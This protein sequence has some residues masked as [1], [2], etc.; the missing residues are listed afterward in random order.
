MN[1]LKTAVRPPQNADQL[2]TPVA[3]GT[4]VINIQTQ[5]NLS[6]SESACMLLVRDG[7]GNLVGAANIGMLPNADQL[8][9]SG[10]GQSG[11]DSPFPN[12]GG[13]APTVQEIELNM[14]GANLYVVQCKQQLGAQ[15]LVMANQSQQVLQSLFRAPAFDIQGPLYSL[16]APDH[17]QTPLRQNST[18][19]QLAIATNLLQQ[20]INNSTGVFAFAQAAYVADPIFVINNFSVSGNSRIINN[21]NAETVVRKV[22]G[23]GGTLT[24]SG[25]G[26]TS[27]ES[28]NGT[29]TVSNTGTGK[30]AVAGETVN[31]DQSVT[32]GNDNSSQTI[33][34][35]GLTINST[36]TAQALMSLDNGIGSQVN[37]FNTSLV[38]DN[39]NSSTNP[40]L[41]VPANSNLCNVQAIS[42]A[43]TNTANPQHI[44]AISTMVENVTRSLL[45]ENVS[46]ETKNQIAG[47]QTPPSATSQNAVQNLINSYVTCISTTEVT[48]NVSNLQRSVNFGGTLI[49]SRTSPK[50][51]QDLMT[52]LDTIM[53]TQMPQMTAVSVSP[54]SAYIG[55]TITLTFTSN[56]SL[57][58][59]PNVTILGRQ[60]SVTNTSDMNYTATT[61]VTASDTFFN[62]SIDNIIG[63]NG[64]I[65]NSVSATTNGSNVTI[66]KSAQAV[67]A[68]TTLTPPGNYDTAL[69]VQLKTSTDNA[70]IKYTTDGSQPSDASGNIYTAPISVTASMTIKAVA[71]LN[72]ATSSIMTAEYTIIP[73]KGTV[74][75][76]IFSVPGGSYTG[77]FDLSITCATPGAKIKYAFF[78]ESPRGDY[79]FKNYSGPINLAA[80][81]I[82]VTIKAYA[83]A[84]GMTG[85][86][87]TTCFYEFSQEQLQA[88]SDPVISPTAGKYDRRQE[89][90]ITCATPGA[91]IV[92]TLD[93]TEP[94][95]ASGNIYAGAQILT[96]STVVKAMAYAAGKADSNVVSENI[97]I[98]ETSTTSVVITEAEPK[99]NG[100]L[101]N[102]NFNINISAPKGT[103]LAAAR[104]GIN[105]LRA[106]ETVISD[107]GNTELPI[108]ISKLAEGKANA[109]IVSGIAID[110]TPAG[111]LTI[112]VTKDTTAPVRQKISVK[113]SNSSDNATATTGDTVVISLQ[114]SEPL[115]NITATIMTKSTVISRTDD[116]NWTVTRKLD[117]TEAGAEFDFLI[118]LTDLA[119]NDSQ[120]LY[121]K[122]D[123][124]EG[125]AIKLLNLS[126]M[127]EFTISR[128]PYSN[129]YLMLSEVPSSMEC[130]LVTNDPAWN[131]RD[132]QN[133]SYRVTGTNQTIDLLSNQFTE[134]KYLY[135]KDNASGK[136]KCLGRTNVKLLASSGYVDSDMN[137]WFFN[138][139]NGKLKLPAISY[140]GKQIPAS[141]L[142]VHFYKN[143]TFLGNAGLEPSD[144][145]GVNV[146]TIPAFAPDLFKSGDVFYY[147]ISSNGG[148]PHD[149]SDDLYTP[150]ITADI[151]YISSKTYFDGRLNA[152]VSN[153]GSN[154]LSFLLLR[155]DETNSIELKAADT[156][157]GIYK[158]PF[159]AIKDDKLRFSVKQ[160]TGTASSPAITFTVAEAPRNLNESSKGSFTID[161][162]SYEI[163]IK[164]AVWNSQ[165]NSSSY[166]GFVS[167]DDGANWTDVGYVSSSGTTFKLAMT[168]ESKIKVSLRDSNG[169]YSLTQAEGVS[170]VAA[171]VNSASGDAAFLILGHEKKFEIDNTSGK[172]NQFAFA[173]SFNGVMSFGGTVYGVGKKKLAMHDSITAGKIKM[174]FRDA[175]TQNVSFMSE[176]YILKA[177]ANR[178]QNAV[179]GDFTVAANEKKVYVNNA[180]SSLNGYTVFINDAEAGK[181]TDANQAFSY[182]A[183]YTSYKVWVYYKD[184]KGN[185]WLKT[186][187]NPIKIPQNGN[188]ADGDFSVSAAE[189]YIMFKNSGGT[190]TGLMPLISRDDGATWKA[191]TALAAGDNKFSLDVKPDDSI[192]VA[193]KDA[194]G[195]I[196]RFSQSCNAPAAPVL[197]TP[198]NLLLEGDGGP[199]AKAGIIVEA[200]KA[201]VKLRPGITLKEGESL[202]I[203]LTNG[204]SISM[205]AKNKYSSDLK[206]VFGISSSNV[207]FIPGA[208]GNG[209]STTGSF[210]LNNPGGVPVDITGVIQV[211][212]A[213]IDKYGNVSPLAKTNLVFD[214]TPPVWE[215]GYPMTEATEYYKLKLSSRLN[216]DGKIYIVCLKS[217]ETAPTAAQ[218]KTGLNA[219]GATV[220]ANCK[221][222]LDFATASGTTAKIFSGLEN[223]TEYSIYSV[224][225]D[226]YENIQAQPAAVKIKTLNNTAP[227]WAS[228]YP[229]AEATDFTKLKLSVMM[230]EIGSV[231]LLCL[232]SNETAPTAAQVKAGLN[233]SGAAVADSMKAA[234][235]MDKADSESVYIF[236]GL[237]TGV[238]YSMYALAQDGYDELQAAPTATRA[239]TP[240]NR[241]PVWTSGYPAVLPS[242]YSAR[243]NLSADKIST[244]YLVCLN[245]GAAAPTAAQVKAGTN[246]SDEVLLDK[247]KGNKTISPNVTAGF[248]F[249]QL[250]MGARYDVYL[251]AE[252]Q[253]GVA[254]AEVSKLTFNTLIYVIPSPTLYGGSASK[255]SLY[256]FDADDNGCIDHIVVRFKKIHFTRSTPMTTAASTI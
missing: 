237:E 90:T 202:K 162:I 22:S 49:S 82:S 196:G 160:K 235:T 134:K 31:P 27:I 117:G 204:G 51:S 232:K 1:N 85:S 190:V 169:N 179:A 12:S 184:L 33:N 215:T 195:N 87:V 39:L 91:T 94:T 102:S 177:A 10:N 79:I 227:V 142:T 67:L 63:M 88:V 166:K 254:Q 43:I 243:I 13:N 21:S 197:A 135:I 15:T 77:G 238:E 118:K 236:S 93:G 225:E 147:F 218:V 138:T 110:G 143:N 83:V 61:T 171:P 59:V 40:V 18:L 58:S 25:T 144:T 153:A 246:A 224:A 203:T 206:P 32:K 106:I 52:R 219:S 28:V 187:I 73:P 158:L 3:T 64:K 152:F 103:R 140:D 188:L 151:N 96:K 62:F 17:A 34:L 156:A 112:T 127:P 56:M 131:G 109:I 157:A 186:Q 137:K 50:L 221:A 247:M 229:K 35:T 11:S 101:V 47:T 180:D 168:P 65:G 241:P 70:V 132:E 113:S 111:P 174:V 242:Y 163:K 100:A 48:N 220:A 129:N 14:E 122:D 183:D 252:N 198:V 192:S 239:T 145:E 66:I 97:E 176:E 105:V 98:A 80:S 76:P 38:C 26:P 200:G 42:N 189:G 72:G 107:S 172:L 228:G 37:L 74:A 114:A 245:S 89:V 182:V 154:N 173:G 159:T 19:T 60:A 248:D 121:N 213:L 124:N 216:K 207:T 249:S 191:E 222:V 125:A 231:Y 139:L 223:N 253:Y 54:A 136:V 95:Y 170:P 226:L 45:S 69:N 29:L 209:D 133:V 55:E 57:A 217:N 251:I 36:T 119:G 149:T 178:S 20:N 201:A 30:V 81:R 250:S 244:V 208:A 210:N 78:E 86:P 116:L 193:F 41:V 115:K 165:T 44:E 108:D 181:I 92:Y 2:D 199:G 128:S 75:A 150:P 214:Q 4:A 233:A 84:E 9:G 234:M 126:Q 205:T 99:K 167:I 146:S 148:T 240:D 120:Y 46:T 155:N 175:V 212:A 141:N 8:S 104:D 24:V 53:N 71:I 23:N 123:I 161:A 5:N 211:S 194:P 6:P 164:S 230:N 185:T 68:P 130:I 7:M 16:T 256:T 255:D